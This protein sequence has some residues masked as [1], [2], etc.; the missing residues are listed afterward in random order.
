MQTCTEKDCTYAG[1]WVRLAAF[2]LDSAILAVGLLA[3]RLALAGPFALLEQTPL[4]GQ[5]LFDHTLQDILFWLLA[6]LYNILLVWRCGAT[7]GKR[8]MNLRVVARD[9]SDPGL[10]SLVYRETVGKYLS[11]FA[12]IG[13][14]MA[15]FTKEKTAL[16]DMLADTRVIYARRVKVYPSAPAPVPAATQAAPAPEAP[17]TV[18]DAPAPE[19]PK[20]IPAAPAPEALQ[21]AQDTPTAEASEAVQDAPAPELPKTI[22]AAPAPEAPQTAQDTPTAE[23]SEAVQDAPAPEAS[24]TEDP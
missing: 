7:P 22:P 9:G 10:F 16:H 19:L 17:E 4:G 2:A 20:T 6:A 15:A 8:V 14:L 3:V 24:K 18:Q 12:C 1:F 11:G 5:V 13:Y 21:T 23:A